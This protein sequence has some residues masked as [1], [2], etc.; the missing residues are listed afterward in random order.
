MDPDL[1]RD[2]IGRLASGV[3]VVTTC[4]GRRDFGTTASAVTSLSLEPPMLLVCLNRSSET[5]TAIAQSNTFAVSILSEGQ[6]EVAAAFARK[7]SD[8]F[9]ERQPLRSPGGLP[10]IPGSVAHLQTT[11]V[12]TALGGTHVVFL[13]RVDYALGSEAS[14]LTYY[15]GQFG[16]FTG[17]LPR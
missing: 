2:V 5:Q 16:R 4:L 14:P 9:G 11:V 15:R 8:K 1:F 6:S 3:T 10:L 13:G 12:E 17:L 7:G